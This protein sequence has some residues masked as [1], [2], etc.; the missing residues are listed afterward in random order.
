LI[1]CVNNRLVLPSKVEKV[2]QVVGS[3]GKNCP[4]S[5]LMFPACRAHTCTP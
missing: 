2:R 1:S 5:M 3:T 4:I